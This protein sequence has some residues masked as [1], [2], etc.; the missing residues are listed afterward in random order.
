MTGGSG[1]IM[2]LNL[3]VVQQQENQQLNMGVGCVRNNVV[4]A[5]SYGRLS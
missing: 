3:E 5:D 1:C 4:D 2:G